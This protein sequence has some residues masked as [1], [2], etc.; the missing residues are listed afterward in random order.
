MRVP[1]AVA[2]LLWPRRRPTLGIANLVTDVGQQCNHVT[3]LVGYGGSSEASAHF[4]LG[5]S[6]LIRLRRSSGRLARRSDSKT[7]AR[8]AASKSRNRSSLG[9]APPE[10]PASAESNYQI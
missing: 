5:P 4:G 3:T 2:V 9:S 1:I 7:F 10:A 6:I 8:T